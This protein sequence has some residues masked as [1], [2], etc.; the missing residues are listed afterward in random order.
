MDQVGKGAAARTRYSVAVI[1]LRRK[2]DR[3]LRHP[4]LGPLCLILLAL[5]LV[6]TIVHG[7]HDQMHEAGE[8]IVCVAFLLSAIVSLAMPVFRDVIVVA[9]RAPR[10]PPTGVFARHLPRPRSFSSQS[11]PLRL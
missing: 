6:F 8:L 9:P 10:G 5:M 11:V 4:L 2:L 7:A 1:E 3:G